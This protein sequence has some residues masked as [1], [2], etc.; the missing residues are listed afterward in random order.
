MRSPRKVRFIRCLFFHCVYLE[1]AESMRAIFE[2]TARRDEATSAPHSHP[3]ARGRWQQIAFQR[4]RTHASSFGD[5]SCL[6]ANTRLR[7]RVRHDG[8]RDAFHLLSYLRTGHYSHV[9]HACGGLGRPLIYLP[10]T[11]NIY[12]KV[13]VE[14]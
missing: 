14:Q 2:M 6:G 13:E 8:R 9:E 12:N 3:H 5:C 1:G 10:L 11:C 4:P 7:E